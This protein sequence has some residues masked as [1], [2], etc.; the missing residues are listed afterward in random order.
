MKKVYKYEINAFPDFDL[1]LPIGAQL[2]SVQLQGH[3]AFIWA[4]VDP[5]SQEFETHHIHC[6]PTGD[7]LPEDQGNYLGTLQLVNQVPLA[8]PFVFHVFD[9]VK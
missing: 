4:V 7:D 5:E 8:T 9:S 3:G 2:L 1:K 6:Y